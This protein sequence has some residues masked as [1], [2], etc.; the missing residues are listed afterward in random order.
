M[1]TMRMASCPLWPR[2]LGVIMMRTR[3]CPRKRCRVVYAFG[4]AP[5][6]APALHCP[7]AAALCLLCRSG[8]RLHSRIP[9][10]G[11]QLRWANTLY[12]CLRWHLCRRQRLFFRRLP[13]WSPSL[14]TA[15]KVVRVAHFHARRHSPH[16]RSQAGPPP[17]GEDK[18]LQRVILV[19]SAVLPALQWRRV[20]IPGSVD[21]PPYHGPAVIW[22]GRNGLGIIAS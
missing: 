3:Q 9:F 10:A 2:I 5:Q 7:R 14:A 13:R 12:R 19:A 18:E 6:L 17:C 1:P 21:A 4:I 16:T 8:G 11:S 22:F 15:R 20:Q